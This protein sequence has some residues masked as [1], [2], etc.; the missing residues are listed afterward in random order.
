MKNIHAY[1]DELITESQLEW[2]DDPTQ[3]V[4]DLGEKFKNISR[5]CDLRGKKSIRYEHRIRNTSNAERTVMSSECS[6][7]IQ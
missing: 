1:I 7:D 5:K 6:K 3:P 4:K 2:E